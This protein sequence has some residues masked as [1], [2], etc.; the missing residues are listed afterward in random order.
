MADYASLIR[1]TGS[2]RVHATRQA[3]APAMRQR[4]QLQL[5]GVAE[6]DRV[7]AVVLDRIGRQRVDEHVEPLTVK[8]QPRHDMIE[9][10]G[11]ED[12]QDIRDRVR[13]ARLVAKPVILDAELL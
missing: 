2:L 10:V 8:H 4:V 6:P 5:Y 13:P 11:L 7:A 12:E 3:A 1:P 9:L